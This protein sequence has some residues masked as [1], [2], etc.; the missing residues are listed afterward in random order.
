MQEAGFAIDE[1]NG[2]ARL[3]ALAVAVQALIG[4]GLS[5]QAKP[6]VD[7]LVA[8]IQAARGPRAEVISLAARRDRDRDRE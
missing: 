4:A 6:L 3:E 2:A 5:S 8:V 1:T 7:E